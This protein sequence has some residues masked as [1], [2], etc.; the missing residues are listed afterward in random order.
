MFGSA[1]AAVAV[2]IQ[3]LASLLS[4]QR[5]ASLLFLQTQGQPEP[6]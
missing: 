3:R 1:P 2:A 4:R 6:Q 5:P